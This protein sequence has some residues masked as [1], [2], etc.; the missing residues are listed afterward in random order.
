MILWGKRHA[1]HS[2][3]TADRPLPITMGT[4]FGAE[5]RSTQHRITGRKSGFSSAQH[6]AKYA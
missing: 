1:L 4:A 3:K 6:S 5:N 2:E